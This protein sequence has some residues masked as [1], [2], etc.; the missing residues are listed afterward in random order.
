MSVTADDVRKIAQLAELDV[1]EEQLPELVSQMSR[2]VDYIAQ[3]AQVPASETAKPFVTGPDAIRFRADEVRPW[4]M[5]FSAKDLAPAF[6]NG[7]FLVPKLDAFGDGAP[8][9]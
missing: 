5:A 1:A 7:F 6:K 2:I 3:L 8:A 9:K 4:P